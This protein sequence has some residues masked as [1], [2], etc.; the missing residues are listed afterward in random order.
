[1]PRDLLQ[2]KEDA[3]SS[4][5]VGT[6]ERF[7]SFIEQSSQV[8]IVFDALDECPEQERGSMIEF[9]TDVVTAQTGCHVKV[10]VTS[11][12]EMD[13]IEAFESKHIPSIQILAENVTPDIQ[14][15]ARD[16]VEKLHVGEHGKRLYVTDD[17]LKELIVQTLSEKAEGMYVNTSAHLRIFCPNRSKTDCNIGFFGSTCS[18]TVSAKLARLTKIM[19]S[20]PHLRLYRKD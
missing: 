6:Q 18:W 20:K 9:I 12:R 19:R 17:G 2:T 5:L 16:R 8:F 3:L 15:F 14:E 7:L 1:M 10:F 13:I 11:R 4:S